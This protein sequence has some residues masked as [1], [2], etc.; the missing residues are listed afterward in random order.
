[1]L[2]W[3]DKC[4]KY[5]VTGPSI[6]ITPLTSHSFRRGGAQPANSDPDLTIQWIAARGGWNM[7]TQH[8]IFNYIVNTTKEDQRVSKVLSG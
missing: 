1:M 5:T 4:W 2:E 7:S 8:K 3:V 6:L